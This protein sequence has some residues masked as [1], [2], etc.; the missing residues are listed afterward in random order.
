V[1]EE[2]HSAAKHD[3]D[4]KYPADK[5]EKNWMI[6][7]KTFVSESAAYDFYNT[8]ANDQGFSIRK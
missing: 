7:E 5:R 2:V 8:Y 3:T 6:M 4:I 1:T